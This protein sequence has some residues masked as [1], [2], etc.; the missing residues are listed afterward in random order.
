MHVG[1]P[2]VEAAADSRGDDGKAGVSGKVVAAGVG[3]A[4]AAAA[5]V[6]ATKDR[7]GGDADVDTGRAG[8]LPAGRDRCHPGHLG[9]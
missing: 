9:C 2:G 7:S 3:V 1:T 4:A 5:A 8:R 6:V